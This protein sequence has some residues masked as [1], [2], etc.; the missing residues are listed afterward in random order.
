MEKTDGVK[1]SDGIAWT[2]NVKSSAEVESRDTSASDP[3]PSPGSVTIKHSVTNKPVQVV[4]LAHRIPS[5]G[6][7]SAHSPKVKSPSPPAY[8]MQASQAK[9]VPST[10]TKGAKEMVGEIAGNSSQAGPSR[11]DDAKLK[12]GAAVVARVSCNGVVE[13]VDGQCVVTPLHVATNM[14]VSMRDILL[15]FPGWRIPLAGYVHS[16]WKIVAL[17]EVCQ[18]LARW[19]H[20]K[21]PNQERRGH[22]VEL[23]GERRRNWLKTRTELSLNR[24]GIYQTA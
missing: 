7:E 5:A 10:L 24:N 11:S 13:R 9:V 6:V 22:V 18:R 3:N 17:R 20:Q 16:P 1:L 19:A 23:D 12:E 15:D 4:D 2:V 14:R 21:D 8:Q